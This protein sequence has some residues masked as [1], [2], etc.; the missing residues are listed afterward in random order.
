MNTPESITDL[1]AYVPPPRSQFRQTVLTLRIPVSF[2]A[3]LDLPEN[4]DILLSLD[5]S[6][7]WWHDGRND[8]AVEMIMRGLSDL[9]K[10]AVRDAK[11]EDINQSPDANDLVQVSPSTQM[12]RGGIALDSWMM[13]A[14]PDVSV[15]SPHAITLEDGEIEERITRQQ[16]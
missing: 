3:Q 16:S 15:G 12:R 4:K 9:L 11:G 2:Y 13:E 8:F 14:K 5:S 6:C 10:T 1:G 7:D